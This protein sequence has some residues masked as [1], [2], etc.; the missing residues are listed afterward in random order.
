MKIEKSPKVSHLDF[1]YTFPLNSLLEVTVA[2]MD[3]WWQ[4]TERL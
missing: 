3:W 2:S 1:V 4:V